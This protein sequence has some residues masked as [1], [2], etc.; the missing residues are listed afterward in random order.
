MT[1]AGEGWMAV[2]K[3]SG[4]T[5]ITNEAM[6]SS[7]EEEALSETAAKTGQRIGTGLIQGSAALAAAEAAYAQ[8]LAK[9]GEFG[10]EG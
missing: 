5:P 9:L 4:V 6:A 8:S 3:R 10:V 1:T 7:A 2:G